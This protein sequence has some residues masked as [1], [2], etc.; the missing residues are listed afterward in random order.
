MKDTFGWAN[1]TLVEQ[2]VASIKSCEN[3][4]MHASKR[5]LIRTLWSLAILDKKQEPEFY[6]EILTAIFADD[7]KMSVP[8]AIVILTSSDL[9]VIQPKHFENLMESL[10]VDLQTEVIFLSLVL[11]FFPSFFFHVFN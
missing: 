11:S 9:D 2:I 4:H 8:E 6:N 10:L 3:F 7:T 1:Q 5:L